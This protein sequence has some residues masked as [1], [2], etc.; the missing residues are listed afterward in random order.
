[1]GRQ[2]RTCLSELPDASSAVRNELLSIASS[3][4]YLSAE[5]EQEPACSDACDAAARR[6]QAQLRAQGLD[7]PGE[8]TGVD[9]TAVLQAIASPDVN[10]ARAGRVFTSLVEYL[11]AC[12]QAELGMYRRGLQAGGR[13]T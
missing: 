4:R 12:N 3:L 2:V 1:M 7:L 13:N 9:V 8:L 11:H 5:L 10:E 6:L